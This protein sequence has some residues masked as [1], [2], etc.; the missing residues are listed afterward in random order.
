MSDA[1]RLTLLEAAAACGLPPAVSQADLVVL[2][3]A[4]EARRLLT[5][6]EDEPAWIAA[7]MAAQLAASA[8][9]D[10]PFTLT[11]GDSRPRPRPVHQSALFEET[12]P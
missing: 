3:A 11:G 6:M 10:L 4:C 1:R 7:R 12:E 5:N 2:A 8:P 9:F